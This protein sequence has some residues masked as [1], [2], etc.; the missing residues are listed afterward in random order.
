MLKTGHSVTRP[1]R[2]L[3]DEPVNI[4]VPEELE[5]AP[6]I[7]QNPQEVDFYSREY[8]LESQAVE[9][10]AD[11]EW[12]W[13]VYT[14]EDWED[15]RINDAMSRPIVQAAHNTGDRAR[16]GAGFRQGCHGVDQGQGQRDGIW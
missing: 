12:A 13:T 2:R 14:E 1:G 8:P 3:G 9:Y 7:V 15:R 4:T 11:R 6:G 16:G 5:T 10:T